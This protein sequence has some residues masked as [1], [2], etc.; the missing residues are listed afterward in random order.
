MVQVASFTAMITFSGNFF[1]PGLLNYIFANMH[2]L[3]SDPFSGTATQ[4]TLPSHILS[5]VWKLAGRAAH[6]R[7]EPRMS[8]WLE[9]QHRLP[10]ALLLLSDINEELI[11]IVVSRLQN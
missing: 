3:S 11:V 9:L 8:P 4:A 2:T 10:Q 6:T 1:M 5:I 7:R